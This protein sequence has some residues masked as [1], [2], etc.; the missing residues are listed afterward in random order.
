[1]AAKP[2]PFFKNA[3]AKSKVT[4]KSMLV[5]MNFLETSL[6]LRQLFSDTNLTLF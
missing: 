2:H 5:H 1:V 4:K 6:R 3:G